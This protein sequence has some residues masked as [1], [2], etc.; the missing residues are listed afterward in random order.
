MAAAAAVAK[1]EPFGPYTGRADVT[2]TKDG[3]GAVS[4]HIETERLVLRFATTKNI[5]FYTK[6][7]GDSSAVKYFATGK[8]LDAEWAKKRLTTWENRIAGGEPFS[9]FIGVS[10]KHGEVLHIIAGQGD[11]AG[12][13]ESQLAYALK[14]EYQ[15]QGYMTEAATAVVQ[16]F[17]PECVEQ[18]YQVDG[19]KLS[20][21]TA[22][23]DPDNQYSATILKRVGMTFQKE[24]KI[25]GYTNQGRRNLYR[26][27]AKDI[28][29]LHPKRADASS[30]QKE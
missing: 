6:L 12:S 10:R 1:R 7:F 17:L 15:G 11:V 21:L 27:D 26:L 8:T 19:A 4:A 29:R 25:D 28:V 30:D 16:A 3:T 24:M 20:Y 14:S 23:A 9:A 18:E 13:G 5:P 22:S 2:L